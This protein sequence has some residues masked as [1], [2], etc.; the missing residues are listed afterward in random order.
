MRCGRRWSEPAARRRATWSSSIATSRVLAE[1]RVDLDGY[2][3][4]FE[5]RGE[6]ITGDVTP[7]YSR[8]DE[9]ADRAV[10]RAVPR[11]QG[12]LPRTR[13]GRAPVVASPDDGAVQG[14]RSIASPPERAMKFAA[15]P[16]VAAAL[17]QQRGGPAVAAACRGGTIR[18]L[19][20][21]RPAARPR[22]AC[23]GRSSGFSG[24]TPMR[25]AAPSRPTSI[26]RRRT[27][28]CRS[29]TTSV[30]ALAVH[31]AD[32]LKTS[33]RELGGAAAAWPEK[34]GLA[35]SP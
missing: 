10:R 33:A 29:P 7:G 11:D 26:A 18:A 5:R 34:Y 32:E 24:R 27:G 30:P 28:S 13:P 20:L 6:A 17:H 15:R 19:L 2:A 25:R 1:D 3:R 16:M 8:L 14:A 12:A 35:P 31:F 4:L 9:T 22:R 21:R 23:A